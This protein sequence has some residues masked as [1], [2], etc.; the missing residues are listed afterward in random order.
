MEM[1]YD[2][3]LVMPSNYVVMNDEEMCYLEGG[4]KL[5]YISNKALK[6]VICGCVFDPI[7]A[8][9]VGLGIRKAVCFVAAKFTAVCTRLGSLGGAV[10][11]AIGFICGALTAASIA[12]TIVDALWNGEGIEIGF[13]WRPYIDAK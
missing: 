9:L 3:A 8:T 2:G 6:A 11:A 7:G 5:A 1:C 13:T 10:G 4:K 12:T